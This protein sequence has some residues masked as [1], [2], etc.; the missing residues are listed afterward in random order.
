MTK[1][2]ENLNEELEIQQ[3]ETLEQDA[4]E[5]QDS[6]E[7]VLTVD[8]LKLQIANLEEALNNEKSKIRDIELRAQAE[9]SNIRR[10]AEQE[11][12]K[13]KLFGLEKIAKD[14]IETVLDNLEKAIEHGKKIDNPDLKPTLDG[15]EM[16]Y[17]IYTKLLAK[18]GIEAVG[19]VGEKF[20]PNFQESVA[21]IDKEGIESG[22]IAE[23]YKVGYKINGKILR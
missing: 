10:R 8:D 22:C 5:A 16:T 9:I 17:E 20:D 7:E 1:H 3:E 15:I 21:A 6:Q 18:Y 2:Q 11:V 14:L 13:E 12:T 19:T 23:V 4:T